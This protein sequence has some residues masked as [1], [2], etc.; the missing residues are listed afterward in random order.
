M[1]NRVLS[2]IVAVS[3]AFPLICLKSK[4]TNINI[5]AASAVVMIA[6]T[7]EVLYEKNAHEERGIA[8]TT[9]IMT[10]LIAIES[11]RLK[12]ETVATKKDVT[13]E[14]TSIGLR[15]GDSVNLSTLVKGML[16]ESGND[17]ANVTATLVAGDNEKFV[18]LMNKRAKALGMNNTSFKNP[19]GLTQ[20]GHYS[21]AYD[22]A[23]LASE[24]IRNPVFREI[25]S[26]RSERVS[27]GTPVYSRTF[28][29]HNKFLKM[30][31]GA[32][33]IKTGY[34]KASGRCLVTAAQRDGV[35]L[36]AVTLKAP[37][38]WQ[39]HI[40]MMDYSFS[41]IKKEKVT[42][43]LSMYKIPVVGSEKE[44]ISGE[45]S[46]ELHIPYSE[47]LPEY[48]VVCF[49]PRFIYGGIEKGDYI[50]WVEVQTVTGAC[51]NK[52]YIVAKEEA[53]E[54][55]VSSDENETFI[56]KIKNIIM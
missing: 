15:D 11:G 32:L 25:A 8:S 19:S 10:S 54:L 4:A 37:D 16:L 35:T 13:I 41:D 2:V 51:I 52:S 45:L 38:D 49:I 31:D 46:G 9:K 23:L 26:S 27:M 42:V 47:A 28:Y 12:R 7:G 53:D 30:Y 20:E 44:S 18:A 43:D 29:N 34:T 50:G 21:T 33:G 39:D 1:L 22:M 6:E 14:G 17:A 55:T 3:L 24:A 36:V 5:S 40:K 48:S 56:E